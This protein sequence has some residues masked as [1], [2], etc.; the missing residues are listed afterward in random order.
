[1]VHGADGWLHASKNNH[2][3]SSRRN[4]RRFTAPI[5]P[6]ERF[7]T[8]IWRDADIVSFQVRCVERNVIAISNGRIEIEA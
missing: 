5:Y 7:L 3:L 4:T 6:G 2:K 8:E 1:M